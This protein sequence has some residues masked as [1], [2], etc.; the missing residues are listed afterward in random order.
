MVWWH[1]TSV[2]TH[3]SLTWRRLNRSADTNTSPPTAILLLLSGML[4][5]LP[6]I[7]IRFT[8][9]LY[10][11]NLLQHDGKLIWL[12]MLVR[13]LNLRRIYDLVSKVISVAPRLAVDVSRWNLERE[14]FIRPFRPRSTK[15]SVPSRFPTTMFMQ[16]SCPSDRDPAWRW[17]WP[18]PYGDRSSLDVRVGLLGCDAVWTCKYTTTFRRNILLPSSGRKLKYHLCT[19]LMSLTSFHASV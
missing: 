7:F 14:Y 12:Y 5:I 15:V 9:P 6:D 1:Y 2:W 17:G 11:H 3:A 13:S 8:I 10:I 16:L 4:D 19:N 18:F